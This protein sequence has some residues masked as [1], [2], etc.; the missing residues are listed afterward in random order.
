[1]RNLLNDTIIIKKPLEKDAYGKVVSWSDPIEVKARF[2]K[3]QKIQVTNDGFHPYTIAKIQVKAPSE[4]EADDKVI[5]E[6]NEY[7]ALEPS[8]MKGYN[9]KVFGYVVNLLNYD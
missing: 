1:M 3:I 6:N 8:Q 9:N 2:V 4:I 5:Y 7:R